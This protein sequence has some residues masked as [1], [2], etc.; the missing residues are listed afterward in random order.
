[1]TGI[2]LNVQNNYAA[3]YN[4]SA[5]QTDTRPGASNTASVQGASPIGSGEKVTLS[6]EAIALSL[7]NDETTIPNEDALLGGGAG[8]RPP[9]VT[10]L[11]GGAGIRPPLAP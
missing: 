2:N 7:Q 6:A 4:N 5:L 10:T 8:I 1:M 9:A 3:L 11:G